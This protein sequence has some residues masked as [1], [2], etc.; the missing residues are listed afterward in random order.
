VIASYKHSSLLGLAVSDEGKKFYNVDSWSADG[1]TFVFFATVV[2]KFSEVYV[3]ITTSYTIGK[4]VFTQ[5][6]K[7][8]MFVAIASGGDLKR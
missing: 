8:Y 1:D 7:H 2:E 3:N 6:R 5:A 4:V